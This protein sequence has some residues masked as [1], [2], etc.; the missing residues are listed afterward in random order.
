MGLE[1]DMG[2]LFFSFLFFAFFV[3]GFGSMH[4]RCNRQ[5]TDTHFLRFLLGGF[6]GDFGR[7]E[8]EGGEVVCCGH[9]CDYCGLV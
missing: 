1:I 8:G 9:D 5:H 3:D 4:C 2:F 7:F 6:G